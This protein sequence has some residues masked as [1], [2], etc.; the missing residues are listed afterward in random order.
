MESFSIAVNG[1]I[2]HVTEL[3]RKSGLYELYGNGFLHTFGR[4]HK[5]KEWMYIRKS[6]FCPLLPLQEIARE[7]DLL[8][9]NHINK[10][11]P[12]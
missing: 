9:Y 1:Q 12:Q 7:L 11:A 5:T 10:K 3:N 6:P 8:I 2:Y 4:S